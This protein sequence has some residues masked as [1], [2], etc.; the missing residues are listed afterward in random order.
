VSTRSVDDLVAALGVAS[1]ISKSEVSRICAELDEAVGAFRTRDLDHIEF[2]YVYLD[3]TYLHVRDDHQVVSKAVVVATGI[4]AQGNREVLGLDV[5]DSEDEVFWR[6]GCRK[7]IR[8]AIRQVFE[9]RPGSVPS[10]TCDPPPLA[11]AP[12]AHSTP[13]AVRYRRCPRR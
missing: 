8:P 4:T 13:M 5:G 12:H 9:P 10:T 11:H 1:G 7:V 3:A 2:P 6:C